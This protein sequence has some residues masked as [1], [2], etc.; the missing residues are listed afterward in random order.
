MQLISAALIHHYTFDVSAGADTGTI[1]GRT[2]TEQLVA[3]FG[4]EGA[5]CVAAALEGDVLKELF[6][7]SFRDEEPPAELFQIFFD[8][9]VEC[10]LA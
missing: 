10:G 3:D 1:G 2:L 6:R 7:A 8:M 5:A 9:A 4:P